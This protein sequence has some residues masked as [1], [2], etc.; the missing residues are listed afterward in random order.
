MSPRLR[1]PALVVAAVSLPLAACSSSSSSST[2]SSGSH[3]SP[4]ATVQIKFVSFEPSKVTIH[5][6]QTVEW[7]WADSPVAHN[8]TFSG[9]G[10]PTQADGTYFH[11][12]DTAGTYT[13]RC[14]VHAT[15]TGEVVVLP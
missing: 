4:S 10:T 3:P 11:T 1:F 14:T 13:Y 2:T 6:G 9:F 8:V 15:M 12:F 7:Q 5:A